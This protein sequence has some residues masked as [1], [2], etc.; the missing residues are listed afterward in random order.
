MAP[1]KRLTNELPYRPHWWTV[2]RKF[3]LSQV[4]VLQHLYDLLRSDTLDF[5]RLGVNGVRLVG[6]HEAS[7]VGTYSL[8]HSGTLFAC[9]QGRKAADV[10]AV[11]LH[12]LF[13]DGLTCRSQAPPPIRT[14]S[15]S[16]PAKRSLNLSIPLIINPKHSIQDVLDLA[17]DAR[18][19]PH[20]IGKG[21][22]GGKRVDS[23]PG[24]W[25]GL[26]AQ[27]LH[28]TRGLL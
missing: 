2:C 19:V 24:C 27:Y 26:V 5:H 22:D 10:I 25:L 15:P 28:Y 21:Q 23:T 12:A 6:L 20:V 18:V 4:D 16:W 13:V 14:Y 8:T 11:F 17:R 9:E 1:H 3:A 7:H